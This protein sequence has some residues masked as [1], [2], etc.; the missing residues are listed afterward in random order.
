[1]K[2]MNMGGRVMP[3]Q[4]RVAP[5]AAAGMAN[6]AAPRANVAPQ[7]MAKAPPQSILTRKGGGAIKYAAGGK[8]CRGK[9]AA[10]RGYKARGPMG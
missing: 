6:R 5:Q 7:A 2:K 3:S 1:M 10:T 4:A 8:V 9:G